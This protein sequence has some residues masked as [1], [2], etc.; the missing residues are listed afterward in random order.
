MS[1]EDGDRATRSFRVQGRVQGVA[2]RAATRS[3]ARELGIDGHARNLPDGSVEVVARGT[4]VALAALE[5][6]LH[7]GPTL[8]RVDSVHMETVEMTV[9]AGFRVG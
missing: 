5:R 3:R 8:A 4:P 1:A 6:F 7:H 2:F 9:A